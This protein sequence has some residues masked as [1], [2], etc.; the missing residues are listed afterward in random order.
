MTVDL[1]PLKREAAE[2][3]IEAEVRSGMVLGL[4]TG[5]TAAWLLEGAGAAAV[6]RARCRG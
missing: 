1:E 5:S 3:A 4:G 2:A 6:G